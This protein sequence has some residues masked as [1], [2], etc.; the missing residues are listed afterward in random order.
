MKSEPRHGEFAVGDDVEDIHGVVG[1]GLL[2]LWMVMCF[3]LY[4]VLGA[5]VDWRHAIVG[6]AGYGTLAVVAYLAARARPVKRRFPP[7][8]TDSRFTFAL[9]GYVGVIWKTPALLEAAPGALA[10]VVCV[11]GFVDGL[12]LGRVAANR[13]CSFG[14]ALE[15][16]WAGGRGHERRGGRTDRKRRY[17]RGRRNQ[18]GQRIRSNAAAR[19]ESAIR[20]QSRPS[21]RKGNRCRL[22]MGRLW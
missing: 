4:F 11:G 2:T 22:M 5:P 18:A 21:K 17:E 16:V 13:G 9:V 19:T 6:A 10:I 14:G 20:N 15:A 7:P 8:F 12:C 3:G 1:S